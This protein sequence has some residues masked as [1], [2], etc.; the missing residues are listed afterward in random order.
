MTCVAIA[1]PD[2]QQNA[3]DFRHGSGLSGTADLQLRAIMNASGIV[4]HARKDTANAVW[5]YRPSGVQIPEPPQLTC[6]LLDIGERASQCPLASKV[7]V[8]VAAAWPAG[9]HAARAPS[10]SPGWPPRRKLVMI[11]ATRAG[12]SISIR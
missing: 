10:V 11:G 8:R 2:A 6:L 5:V 3:S 12:L 9:D 7:A 4:R 1:W